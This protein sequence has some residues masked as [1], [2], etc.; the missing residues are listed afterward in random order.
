M[1]KSAKPHISIAYLPGHVFP[2]HPK[3][4][5]EQDKHVALRLEKIRVCEQE[6]FALQVQGLCGSVLSKGFIFSSLYSSYHI[7]PWH[8]PMFAVHV[9]TSVS[10][11]PLLL[12]TEKVESSLWGFYNILGVPHTRLSSTPQRCLPC[13]TLTHPLSPLE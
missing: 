11:F 4:M 2:S 12:P 5:P 7:R 13:S 8:R 1:S 10:P 9:F 6:R 3:S